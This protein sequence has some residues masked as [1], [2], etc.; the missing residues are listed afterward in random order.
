MRMLPGF[1][2]LD[3]PGVLTIDCVYSCFLLFYYICL[4][5][6]KAEFAPYSFVCSSSFPTRFLFSSLLFSYHKEFVVVLIIIIIIK[7]K[8]SYAC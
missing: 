6:W 4:F 3:K 8:V 7:V 1:P 5:V 2:V